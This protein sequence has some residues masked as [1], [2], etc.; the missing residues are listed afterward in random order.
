MLF[1]SAPVMP[2]PAGLDWQRNVVPENDGLYVLDGGRV[3]QTWRAVFTHVAASKQ[4][5]D[6]GKLRFALTMAEDLLHMFRVNDLL[7]SQFAH[8]DYMYFTT[9]D[10][11]GESVPI[12]GYFWEENVGYKFKHRDVLNG[13]SVT[14]WRRK[15]Q[16]SVED[17]EGVWI[18]P[19]M[20]VS[21]LSSK[22]FGNAFGTFLPPGMAGIDFSQGPIASINWFGSLTYQT[23][24]RNGGVSGERQWYPNHHLPLSKEMILEAIRGFTKVE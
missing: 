2:A 10:V 20:R 13:K 23:R 9:D 17:V 14:H 4:I 16:R 6:A 5:R 1:R 18:D 24:G 15:I 21:L 22:E 8:P 12:D 11:N 7:H 3:M 19:T